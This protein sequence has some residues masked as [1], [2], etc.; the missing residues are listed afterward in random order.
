MVVVR[1]MTEGESVPCAGFIAAVE[2]DAG[3]GNGLESRGG[4][5]AIRG[6]GALHKRLQVIVGTG[7]LG[8]GPR[9]IG[10]AS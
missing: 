9:G 8:V 5:P 10:L 3:L 4:I 7:R 6:A 1:V 2:R